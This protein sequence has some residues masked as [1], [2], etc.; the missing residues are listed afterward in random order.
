MS[1]Q[2]GEIFSP[3][4]IPSKD[5]IGIALLRHPWARS[6]SPF[7]VLLFIVNDVATRRGHPF[8]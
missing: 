8:P 6:A 1:N 5:N 7:A 3:A 4:V 2:A